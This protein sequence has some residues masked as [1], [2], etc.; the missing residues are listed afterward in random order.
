M[1]ARSAI[2]YEHR[3]IVLGGDG[4]LCPGFG[5][6]NDRVDHQRGPHGYRQLDSSHP[7]YVSRQAIRSSEQPRPPCPHGENETVV[8]DQSGPLAGTRPGR[9]N[10]ALFCG[11]VMFVSVPT[12]RC[13][14]R[15][16]AH[17]TPDPAIRGRWRDGGSGRGQPP[18]LCAQSE[19]SR[20]PRGP[21]R[22]PAE[23][24]NWRSWSSPTRSRT[25]FS[26]RILSGSPGPRRWPM[27]HSN[28]AV[29]LGLPVV[30]D[31]AAPGSARRQARGYRQARAQGVRLKTGL[32]LLLD[33][34]GLTY[35]VV[36]EDNLLILTD[37]QGSEDPIERVMAE[38]HEL[39]RDIHDIQ[40]ALDEVRRID[41]AFGS[42]RCEC[43]GRPSS[44]RC[45]RTRMPSH[46][47]AQHPSRRRG[48]SQARSRRD[49]PSARPRT[50]L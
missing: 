9:Y 15:G 29:S 34:V 21:R 22:L 40:D 14:R 48:P 24:P 47:K 23:S 11:I 27:S 45:P 5:E 12:A 20:R 1:K 39:H 35:K 31:L 6:W 19:T 13:L 49:V 16:V 4:A 44:R 50:S 25:R 32:K 42:G 18:V 17:E 30:L 38:I 33:Q 3:Q 36:A 28:S 26:S 41:R 8:L 43:A 2:S 37:K 46:K 7:E 10:V